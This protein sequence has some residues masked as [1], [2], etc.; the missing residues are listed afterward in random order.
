MVLVTTYTQNIFLFF[1]P[2]TINLRDFIYFIIK[3]LDIAILI[4]TVQLKGI[5]YSSAVFFDKG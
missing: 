1:S 5:Y 3:T 4:H 2:H